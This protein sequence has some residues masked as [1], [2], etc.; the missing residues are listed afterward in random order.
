MQKIS[1]ETKRR[2]IKA[3]ERDKEYRAVA[4]H[5]QVNMSSAY[6]SIRHAADGSV[7]G[8][9]SGCQMVK[10]D[11]EMKGAL[12]YIVEE[13]SGYTLMQIN[14]T[15]QRQL[16]RKPRVNVSTIV[17]VLDGQL[18]KIK[19]LKDALIKRNSVATKRAK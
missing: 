5:L 15:L 18:L 2:I 7:V 1:E 14:Q 9:K 8:P 12:I 4:R 16:P 11:N 13:T 10:M 6:N 19:K 17:A 3:H